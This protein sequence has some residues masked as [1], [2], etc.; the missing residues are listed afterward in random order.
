MQNYTNTVSDPPEDQALEPNTEL[1]PFEALDHELEAAIT[2]NEDTELCEL[3][4]IAID[5][6]LAI[7]EDI[8][9]R[10]A[11]LRVRMFKLAKVAKEK[12]VTMY[13]VLRAEK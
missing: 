9:E 1:M 2:D 3:E 6:A 5:D 13:D 11:E 4:L 8:E 10:E 12:G 7:Q